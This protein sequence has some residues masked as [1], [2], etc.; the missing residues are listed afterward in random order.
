M[1]IVNPFCPISVGFFGLLSSILS[2]RSPLLGANS[3]SNP[4]EGEFENL[5]IVKGDDD[6]ECDELS[7]ARINKFLEVQKQQYYKSIGLEPMLALQ[8]QQSTMSPSQSTTNPSTPDESTLN[9]GPSSR[10]ISLIEEAGDLLSKTVLNESVVEV[11]DMDRSDRF[12]SADNEEE[13][14]RGLNPGTNPT[15]LENVICPLSEPEA[16]D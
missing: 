16:N 8:P 7:E 9:A 11:Y 1:G 6:D 13:E 12:L 2:K 10:E 5:L 14:L 15:Q 3:N 4:S